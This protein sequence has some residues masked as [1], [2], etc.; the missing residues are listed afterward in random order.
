MGDDV[1]VGERGRRLKREIGKGGDGETKM[2]MLMTFAVMTF[3]TFLSSSTCTDNVL[4]TKHH[5]LSLNHF[6]LTT[7][8]SFLYLTI[9]CKCID[10][11]ASSR[12]TAC[13]I[14]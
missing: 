13:N 1:F 12:N 4:L 10:P 8:T 11:P 5:S 14:Y 9:A 2:T 7:I 6:L 3:F